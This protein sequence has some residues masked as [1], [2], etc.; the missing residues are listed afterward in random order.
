MRSM[1]C[2]ETSLWQDLGPLNRPLN[3]IIVV[4]LLEGLVAQ[5]KFSTESSQEILFVQAGDS[6]VILEHGLVISGTERIVDEDGPVRGYR[7]E[8]IPGK[9]ILS[10]PVPR[11]TMFVVTY[12]H[13]SDRFSPRIE[14]ILQS[15]PRLGNHPAGDSQ[16]V[17]PHKPISFDDIPLVTDGTLFRGISVSPS[18]GLSLRGG[19]HLG[20]QGKLSDNVTVSGT[21]SDQN[22]PIQPEGNTQ[23]L[24][25]IDK[26][27][28]E[29]NHPSTRILAGDID[30][31]IHNGPFMDVTRRLEGLAVQYSGKKTES[32][33]HVASTRGKFHRMEFQGED[34]NQG[35]Y[36]LFSHQG[37][38]G[39][40][41]MA[42]SE[43]VWIDGETLERGENNDYTIDYSR[44]EI[45]FTPRQV[46]DSNSRIYVEYEYSDLVYPRQIASGSLKRYLG[47]GKSYFSMASIRESDNFRMPL[48]FSL[49]EEE[50]RQLK[51][52]GDRQA[53]IVTAFEDT[54]GQYVKVPRREDPDD[55][56]FVY[57]PSAEKKESD[58]YLRV[59]FYDAGPRGEYARRVTTGGEV[60]FEYV[61]E[62]SRSGYSDLYVPWRDLQ[63]PETHQILNFTTDIYLGQSTR[64]VLNLAG[65]IRDRNLLST[66]GDHN[67]RGY[68]GSMELY[69][70]RSLPRNLGTVSLTASSR[71]VDERFSPLQRDR[72]VEFNREWNLSREGNPD[73]GWNPG[74]ERLTELEIS[75]RL[76]DMTNSGL[77]FGTYEDGGQRSVRWQGT[78]SLSFHWVPEFRADVTAVT[79]NPAVV[80]ERN[81]ASVWQRDRIYARFMPGRF[82]PFFRYEE[83]ERSREFKFREAGAGLVTEGDRVKFHLGLTHRADYVSDSLALSWTN[84][85]D[86][87]LGELNL[88]GRWRSGYRLHLLLKRRIKSYAGEQ[89]N[90]DYALARGNLGYHP[91]GGNVRANVDF[92]LE[93]TLY[94]E[95][96]AVYDSIGAGEGRYRYDLHYDQYFPDPN[97]SYVERYLP[98]GRRT[99]ASHLTTGFKFFYNFRQ[100]EIPYLQDVTWRLY[101]KGDNSASALTWKTV[102]EPS[103]SDTRVNQARIY[104]EQDLTYLPRTGGRRIRLSNSRN[105]EVGG[106]KSHD[107]SERISRKHSLSVEEPILPSLTW[108]SDATV[109][110]G[111]VSSPVML[112]DR[113]NKGWFVNSGLRWKP[114]KWFEAGADLRHGGDRGKNAYERFRLKITGVGVHAQLFP[115]KGGRIEASVDQYRVRPEESVSFTLPPEVALGLQVGKTYR[116]SLSAFVVFVKNISGN[117][118]VSYLLDPIHDGILTMSG[119]IRANF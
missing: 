93:Q 108:V 116:C 23:T 86:S 103:L 27:Y 84:K 112:R 49:S 80:S 10:D 119:E 19:L 47:N 60:Y 43:R 113:R 117:V 52:L 106:R 90:L 37:S 16:E 88:R 30:M 65:S 81:V 69:H 29:V 13:F 73:A 109:K 2:Q 95:K 111:S 46:I 3:L 24:D 74:S 110:E 101:G 61:D 36:P 32:N 8:S 87:W 89:D 31:A 20:L 71:H 38:R 18:G 57:V 55:T 107:G 105:F 62:Q 17:K 67:N 34:G 58:V 91:R 56:I 70:G 35:P 59:V 1:P 41:V 64:A 22:I 26:V 78:T 45:T 99:P 79:R 40:I 72:S 21:L 33:L 7:L 9:I 115:R 42:S 28:L 15:L 44:G 104:L 5:Q 4:G 54:A 92:K 66:A 100:T 96:T 11:S 39:I 76:N 14:P 51:K 12:E 48:S 68:A 98:L 85:S 25:E 97:G 114:S 75:H 50:K 63:S 102:L 53:R 94:Q 118:N 82:H 6:T 83:E 77:S